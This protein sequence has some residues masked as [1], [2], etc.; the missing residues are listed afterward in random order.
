M[1]KM[2]ENLEKLASDVETFGLE[3]SSNSAIEKIAAAGTAI[4]QLG[5]IDLP[6][7]LAG[8]A[9]LS[10]GTTVVGKGMDEVGKAVENMKY[11]H[12][13]DNVVLPYAKKH[14]PALRNIPDKKLGDW[15]DSARAMAPR[16]AKDKMLASTYLNNVHALGGQA[17]LHTASTLAQIGKNTSTGGNMADMIGGNIGG[18]SSLLLG[19]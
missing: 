9:A 16:V 10:L 3:D 19:A 2:A 4:G 14:N 5:M 11:E 12:K 1:N 13:K 7:I 8:A 18:A 15:L 17:D 6:K